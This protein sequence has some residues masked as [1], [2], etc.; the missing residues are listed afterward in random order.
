[1]R[2]CVLEIRDEGASPLV[3]EPPEGRAMDVT[4]VEQRTLL[5]AAAIERDAGLSVGMADLLIETSGV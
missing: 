3:V 5:V 1:M 4:V 2:S